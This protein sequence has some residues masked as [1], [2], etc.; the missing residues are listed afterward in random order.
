MADNDQHYTFIEEQDK[1]KSRISEVCRKYNM[2]EK[3]FK[4]VE[5]ALVADV[6]K[7]FMYCNNYKVCALLNLYNY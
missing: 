4:E 5:W 7:K 1:R 3:K 6:D 2:S